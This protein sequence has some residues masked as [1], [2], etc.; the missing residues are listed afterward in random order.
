MPYGSSA[1]A[2]VNEVFAIRAISCVAI[3]FYHAVTALPQHRLAVSPIDEY[4]RHLLLFATP[5]FVIISELVLSFS[6]RNDLDARRFLGKRL[7]YIFAPYCC[8]AAVG[9]AVDA[10]QAA[11]ASLWHWL[12]ATLRSIA[13]G[14]ND[15]YFVLII[16]QFYLLH[17]ALRRRALHWPMIPTLL[18]SLLITLAWLSA[19]AYS[20]P[21]SAAW[22]YFWSRGY[23]MFFPGWLFYF[24]AAYYIGK[25]V[26]QVRQWLDRQRWPLWLFLLCL[27]LLWWRNINHQ[28]LDIPISSKTPDNLIYTFVVFALLFQ[29]MSR[30][31]HTP[32]LLAAISRYS[33]TIYLI[34]IPFLLLGLKILDQ[35]WID[36]PLWVEVVIC[37]L[38]SLSLSL[39]VASLAGRWRWS[40]PLLGRP[41][42]LP[43][44]L[45]PA[46]TTPAR[47]SGRAR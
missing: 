3:V 37:A 29:W 44:N 18:V 7:T 12:A 46:R 2:L 17:L 39:A 31:R 28:A 43:G 32:R 41:G 30:W 40:W 5:L 11:D 33:F 21:P 24:F 13:F 34:H 6:D 47:E 14:L 38:L 9:T 19:F 10:W 36:L 45:A 20:K 23:W 35:P 8:C 22:A 42:P 1:K 4:T 26:V 27:P 16:F 25:H 15:G